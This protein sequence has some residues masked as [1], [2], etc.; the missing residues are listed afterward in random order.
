[1]LG[2]P[3]HVTKITN[4]PEQMPG[5]YRDYKIKDA[6]LHLTTEGLMVR[7]HKGRA[8]HFSL[9]LPTSTNT[10]EAALLLAG[11]DLENTAPDVRAPLADRWKDKTFNGVRFKDI[12]AMKM[13][14]DGRRYTTIQVTASQ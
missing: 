4:D 3:K 9:D 10:P 6:N 12:A 2:E 13:D 7:F 1:M 11:V 8:I 5:E 14:D